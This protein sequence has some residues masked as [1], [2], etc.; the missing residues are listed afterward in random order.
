MGFL[1]LKQAQSSRLADIAQA[2]PTSADFI[3][4]VNEAT[5]ALLTRGDWAGT[6][7]PIRVCVRNGCVTWPRYVGKVRRI[8]GCGENI[9]IGNLWYEF[10]DH[11]RF[12]GWNHGWG[13]SPFGFGGLGSHGWRGNMGMINR[14]RYPTY[15]DIFPNVNRLVRAHCLVQEDIGKTLTIFGLDNN[16]Q[17]LRTHDTVNNVWTDGITIT[18]AVPFGSTSVYVSKIDRVIKDVTQGDVPLYAYD[19]VNNV[20]EDLAFYAPSETN[21]SYERDII[22]TTINCCGNMRSV[23]ALVKLKFIPV[24]VPNDLI[25]ISNVRAL[26]F[27]VQ[28]I[29]LEEAGQNE[30][31]A[32][33]MALAVKELN[34]QLENEY[35]VDQ[36]SVDTGFSGGDLIGSQ[37]CI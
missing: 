8:N 2:C 22:K 6:L 18:L 30:A 27:A 16:G 29:R 3:S 14:G 11:D 34:L 13:N 25:L 7:V 17:V 32:E 24:S 31:G 15:N 21:P 28:A 12:N 9:R 36:T 19:P 1:T 35:P 10:I 4:L 23:E 33:K 37:K 5:E 20:E 26:K